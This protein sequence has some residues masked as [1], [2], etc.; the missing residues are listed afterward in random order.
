MIR[1]ALCLLFCLVISAAHAAPVTPGFTYQGRLQDGAQPANGLFDFEFRLYQSA[2]GVDQIGPVVT[3]ND[4]PVEQGVFS[5]LLNF[6]SVFDGNGRWLAIA[7]RE[8][9]SAGN[10]DLLSPRQT[11]TA[12]PYAQ[13]ALS[14]NPGPAG[15]TGPAGPAG[16]AGPAGPVGPA[17]ATGP[18]G[19]AGPIGP[20]GTTGPAGPAGPAG[21]TGPAGPVG[22]TGQ[23]GFTGAAG[24]A[25]QTGPQ[26][27]SGVVGVHT[28]SGSIASIPFGGGAPWIFAGPTVTLSV[29]AGQRVTGSAVAVIG[30]ASAQPQ[31][32]AFALCYSQTAAGSVLLP[33]FTAFLDGTVPAAP[34]K[35]A[36]P[37]T[38]SLVISSTG[39]YRF[40]FCIKNRSTTVSL[41]SNDFANGWFM[42][43]N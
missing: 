17:G 21:A 36:L 20:A 29:T 34:N 42:V 31:Q 8:G 40:G 18:T 4:I 28:T 25:G 41:D 39:T 22:A 12:A 30:H 37:A 38:A 19:P 9:A 32:V 33:F 5:V 23:T 6:G 24:P 35:A 26:G 11:L 10:F 13:Y 2:A 3:L 16:A 1:I 7:V 43:T 15:A 14:G 27:P